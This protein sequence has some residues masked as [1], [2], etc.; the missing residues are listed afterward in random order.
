MFTKEKGPWFPG[1]VGR[2]NLVGAVIVLACAVLCLRLWDL[3]VV[4]WAEFRQLS[5]E[6]RLRIQRIPA[7][8]GIILGWSRGREV[9][10]ADNRAAR[11][12]MFVPAECEEHYERI[13]DPL[14][15]TVGI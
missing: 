15:S 1:F 5:D 7:P 10:V 9:V 3:Q 4:R 13:A 2:L 12:L 14:A 8:R 11:D 6:N